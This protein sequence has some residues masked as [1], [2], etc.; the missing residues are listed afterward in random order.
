MAPAST[1]STRYIYLLRL[2]SERRML[3][4]LTLAM[5]AFALL[6]SVWCAFHGLLNEIVHTY[7]NLSAVQL[8]RRAQQLLND[9]LDRER[10]GS[11]AG[12]EMGVLYFEHST[13]QVSCS[14]PGCGIIVQ[15]EEGMHHFRSHSTRPR[16]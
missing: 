14:G 7:R 13:N 3:L 4:I 15:Q 16:C 2:L 12:T 11:T 5:S 10:T 1:N 6:W 8:L 9:R